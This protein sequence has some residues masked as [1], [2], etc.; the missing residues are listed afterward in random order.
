VL[1]ICATLALPLPARADEPP[2][3]G[4]IT[5]IDGDTVELGGHRWRLDGI[6]APEIHRAQCPRERERGIVGAA[7]LIA[8]LAERGPARIE[9]SR[10][11]SGRIQSGGFGRRLGRLM[12]GDGT[13]WADLAI[14][15]GHAVAWSYRHTPARP[16]WCAGAVG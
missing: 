1:A 2:L 15:E 9:P 13:A 3:T 5:V 10:S 7:R 12:L 8:L 16:D 6:D 4:V 11:R 14:R